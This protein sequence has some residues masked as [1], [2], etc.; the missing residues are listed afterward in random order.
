HL[1]P[2]ESHIID[3][4]AFL[5]CSPS[6]LVPGESHI[7]D[8]AA[9]LCCSP[10]VQISAKRAGSL[11]TMCA[12]GQGLVNTELIG[13]GMIMYQSMSAEKLLGP[14]VI[15]YQSMSTEKLI[16]P[17]MVMYQSM[18]AEKVAKFLMPGQPQ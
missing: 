13:P 14:G 18:S 8:N 2:G 11:A 9:F 5:R 15:T 7:I 3:N 17:G 16:G 12:G 4:A 10:S 6:H 1:V